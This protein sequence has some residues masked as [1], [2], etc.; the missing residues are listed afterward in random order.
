MLELLLKLFIGSYIAVYIIR[1]VSVLQNTRKE[2]KLI[3]EMIDVNHNYEVALERIGNRLGVIKSSVLKP[4][5]M[6][7]KIK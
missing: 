4:Y 2:I 5:I 3:D 7:R 6:F 1:I